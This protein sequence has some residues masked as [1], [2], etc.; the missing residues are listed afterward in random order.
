VKGY[1]DECKC[2]VEIDECREVAVEENKKLYQGKCPEC[3]KEIRFL[4]D[5]IRNTEI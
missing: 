5:E 1:C 3:G 4:M 2:N